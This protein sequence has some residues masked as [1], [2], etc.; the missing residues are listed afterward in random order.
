MEFQS[1]R[2]DRVVNL[3]V[4]SLEQAPVRITLESPEDGLAALGL[5]GNF[6]STTAGFPLMSINL[7]YQLYFL[8]CDLFAANKAAKDSEIAQSIHGV[9]VHNDT[10]LLSEAV[11]FMFQARLLMSNPTVLIRHP[12]G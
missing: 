2:R 1:N 12:N 7:I 3:S 9:W 8:F 6:S 11:S 5:A 10:L 4:H